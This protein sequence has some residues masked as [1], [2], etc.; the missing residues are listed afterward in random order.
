MME[1]LRIVESRYERLEQI[2]WWDQDR[3]RRARVLVA[4]AGAL[5]N[6]ILKHL[7]LLGIGRIVVV[8]FDRVEVSNLSRSVLF[9]VG[10]RGRPKVGVV[11]ER[12]AE[13]NPEIQVLPLEGELQAVVGLG[14]VRRMD[15][16]LAGLDSVGSR[17]ALNQL[18]WRAGVPWFDGAVDELAGTVRVFVPPDGPCFECGLT[19]QD[20]RLAAA[21]YS[22]QLLPRE[23]GIEN[24]V[25]TT[26]TSASM[27]AA[28]QVQEAVKWLHGKP[29]AAGRGISFYG[30]TYEFFRTRFRRRPSCPVHDAPTGVEELPD[31]SSESTV[32]DLLDLLAGRLGD[33]AEVWLD[34]EVVLG[35]SCSR[36][37]VYTPMRTAVAAL[38]PADGRCPNC[39]EGRDPRLTHRL[40]RDGEL[41]ELR[42]SDLGIP[43]LHVL[44]ARG[45]D[46]QTF[47]FEL[48][49]DAA[50]DPF[51]GFLK[52]EDEHGDS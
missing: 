26:P 18:C 20:Y 25:P 49:G 39:G 5:G 51:A 23:A 9:R 27:V 1:P 38:E 42:L 24:P 29:V 22:C 43:P 32:G 13:L 31:I 34:R 28:W 12:M 50:R 17:M 33:G 4:G 35:L 45:G 16:V 30:L 41:A 7:A 15:V 44:T 6:E 3:L 21:R 52:L 46:G 19:D 37:G 2:S 47:D 8:D 14:L 48:S 36:C 11:A 10:D 40:G